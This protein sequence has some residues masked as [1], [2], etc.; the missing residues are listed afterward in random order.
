MSWSKSQHDVYQWLHN[1]AD[2]AP[3]EP[4]CSEE[5]TGGLPGSEPATD[6]PIGGRGPKKEDDG[7]DGGEAECPH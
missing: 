2:S 7:A 1:N 4:R 5:G 6:P 3:T